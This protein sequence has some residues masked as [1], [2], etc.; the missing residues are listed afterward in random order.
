MAE[1]LPHRKRRPGRST[2]TVGLRDVARAAGVSTATVSRTINTPHVVSNEV[3]QRVEAVAE[4]LGWVPD[5]AAR[6]LST[7]RSGA[8]GAV[9][10]V[11]THGDFARATAAL[12]AE[13]Q[14]SGYTLL[15]ACSDYDL[16]QE[17]RQ[18]RKFV[19]RGVEGLVLVG[20]NHHPLL[21]QLL[22]KQQVPFVNTFVYSRSSH[23]A[24]IG[25][26]NRKALHKMASYLAD[27]G[28]REFG[29]LA[30][31]TRNNDRAAARLSGVRDA[32]SERGLAVR[33]QHIAMG[34]WTI[35]EGRAMFRRVVGAS[36]RPTAVICGNAYLAVGAVLECMAMGLDVPGDVS[37]VGYDDIEIMSE[38]PVPITTVRVR[39][40]E[41]GRHTARFI[42]SRIEQTPA[43]IVFEWEAE[44]LVRR[45]SGPP[46]ASGAKKGDRS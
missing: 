23:G 24:C 20:E 8:I 46:P 17:Y 31:S 2:G 9:F 39:G 29:V 7:R 27:L 36:P 14:Q 3:R 6:A 18:V 30:Q 19:E 10:P 42:V 35:G 5:G 45:S 1:K 38:L 40:D 26:D 11:L 21:L 22:D 34:E 33:P 4:R 28:H 41:I 44:L 25:P 32:L 15:L 43:D 13:L 37:I 12:Q 16:D